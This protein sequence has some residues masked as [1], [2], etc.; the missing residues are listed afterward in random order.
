[1]DT[2]RADPLQFNDSASCTRWI[3]SLP[4]TN[5]EASQH[6]L[7]QQI[8][9]VRQAGLAPLE[10]LRVLEALRKPAAYVQNELAHKYVGKPQPLDATEAAWWTRA[11][12]LWQEFIAAYAVCRDAHLRG[13]PGVKNHGALI[14]MRCLGYTS[15]AM[16][17]HYR[18]YRQAPGELWKQLHQLYAFAEQ[19]GFAHTTLADA[20]NHQEADS[21]CATTYHQAL[22]VQLASP[23]ALSGRQMVVVARWS[24]NWAGLV[25]LAAEPL[26]P[27]AIPALAVDLAADRGPVLATGLAPRASLRY[28]DLESLAGTLRQVM[29]ALKQG[30]TPA[31]LDL[32]ADAR[33]PGC[34][35]LL[36]LLYIQWCRA[37]I[38]R[39]EQR[40]PAAENA[41]LRFGMRAAHIYISERC[42]RTPASGER[43]AADTWQLV[44]Q[45][46]SGFMCMARGPDATPRIS[47]NQLVCVHRDSDQLFYLGLVLWLCVE[48]DH[49]LRAGGRLFPGGV[50]AVAVRPAAVNAASGVNDDEPVLSLQDCR[51]WLGSQKSYGVNGYERG[52]LLPEQPARS[53][54]ATVILPT[55]WYHHGR[56]IELR[57]DQK[58][59]AKLCDLLEKGSDFE[60]CTFTL[61]P[62]L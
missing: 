12:K 24:A 2:L 40:F 19:G 9:L 15:S 3:E 28:L 48:D 38:G 21:S 58:Q 7:T 18:A 23:F 55:G 50:R 61:E 51:I 14:V 1:M 43:A 34:G 57:G 49:E 30:Q 33:E 11:L 10:L 16:F 39:G 5:V 42:G 45:S 52:L 8:S 25:N 36:M 37:G 59:I 29:T 60:R 26:P 6:A 4:L 44:N 41:Q 46:S 13:D 32:G 53:T 17:E 20:F 47:H 62:N 31:Q 22:L 56:C 27:S 35:S 54:P